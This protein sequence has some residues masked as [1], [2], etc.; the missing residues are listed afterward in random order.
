M[1][2]SKVRIFTP[3]AAVSLDDLI[4]VDH[5]YRHLDRKLD[6]PFVRDPVKETYAASGRPSIDPVVIFK[7]QLVMF[8]EGIRSERQLVRHAADSRR[9]KTGMVYAAFA[10]DCSGASTLRP[11]GSRLPKSQTPAQKARVG[12]PPVP[13]RGNVGLF[14]GAFVGCARAR[15]WKGIVSGADWFSFLNTEDAW[16]P[17]LLLS[18]SRHFSTGWSSF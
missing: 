11:C 14:L 13:N 2:G 7:L 10:Y 15:F 9:P 6:L 4:P 8:F 18:L 3:I 12:T 1:M 17:S 5:F 16:R